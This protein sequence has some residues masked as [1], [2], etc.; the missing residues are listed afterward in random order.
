MSGFKAGKFERHQ[1]FGAVRP[2]CPTHA[3]HK[4]EDVDPAALANRGIKLI[5]IDVDNTLVVWRKEDFAQET[6]D[7]IAKAKSHD[8]QI[9]IL[10]NTRNPERLM[11]LAKMLDIP[12][13][14]GKFKPNPAMYKE[15]LKKF[16]VHESQA[17]MIGDQIFTDIL[18]ANRAGIESIWLQPISPHDFVGTKV[19][20]VG[21]RLLRGYLYR[22]L[23][24]PIDLP[25]T[26]EEAAAKPF[27]ERKIVHQI[28][29]FTIVGGSSF[30]IDYCLRMTFLFAPPF[31]TFFLAQGEWLRTHVPALFGFYRTG[32]DAIFPVAVT[33]SAAVAI[34]NSFYWNRM[35]TFNIRG[36]ANRGEQL[37]R[38][39]VISVVGLIFNVILST[40]FNHMIPGDRK[41]A[42][43]I[44]TVLAAVLVA[45]WNFTAQRLYAFKTPAP[46]PS[47]TPYPRT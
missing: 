44:A 15:A 37:K 26:P 13:L 47:P 42:A 10:S 9:V 3:V 31:S 43:R 35:W 17:V 45:V 46:E 39:I 24:E 36:S 32:R 22:S 2:F 5:M 34:L 20:R 28:V 19:S 29:K 1:V 8:I 30:V 40:G 12:A 14:R 7:W 21:E 6:L 11:R 27:W 38:F 33:C 16:G 23:T 18:G 25:E 4:L 41:N